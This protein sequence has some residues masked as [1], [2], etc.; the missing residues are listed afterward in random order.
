M[1][2]LFSLA[3]LSVFFA[4]QSTSALTF[5]VFGNLKVVIVIILSVLIFQ[6]EVLWEFLPVSI[7]QYPF[8]D[9]LPSHQITLLNGLG[10]L[11]A[12][13]GICAYSYQEYNIKETKRLAAAR[14]GMKEIRV[15]R[16]NDD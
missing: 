2:S 8:S 4:I 11:V 5:T 6:N 10:C 7:S 13:V 1:L 14:E 12:F 3:D 16:L 9:Q 15:E